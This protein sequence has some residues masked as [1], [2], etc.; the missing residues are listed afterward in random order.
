MGDVQ[1]PRQGDS[2]YRPIVAFDF[3][4]TLTTKDSFVAF[5]RW[6]AGPF[7]YCSGVIKMLPELIAYLAYRDR[8][9]LKA[10][11]LRTFLKGVEKSHFEDDARRFAERRARSLLRPDAVR[12]WRSWQGRHAR[13]AIVTAAPEAIAAPFARGLGAHAL[14]ATQVEYD[15][16]GRI[17]GR[18]DGPNCRGQ[19]KV[20]RLKEVFGDDFRLEAAYGDTDGDK[21]ML[22]IAEERG[23][24]VFQG[25]P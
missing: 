16:E 14:I 1:D 20:R 21:P 7:R 3:D 10:A 12:A 5:L 25:A 4:G 11:A 9:R 6:R 22:A 15:A 19:E 18:L 23:F 24:K 17:T 13:L 2:V 8:G